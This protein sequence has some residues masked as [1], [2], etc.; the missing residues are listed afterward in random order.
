MMFMERRM[1]FRLD[2]N[3][4][5]VDARTISAPSQHADVGNA[6]RLAFE[7]GFAVPE[8]FDD[9]LKKLDRSAR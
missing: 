4:R 8:E 1:P 7:T 2:S 3:N 6:L 9:L 5:L